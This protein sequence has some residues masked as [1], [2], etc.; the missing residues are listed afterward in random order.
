MDR[1]ACPW[2]I[3]RFIDPEAQFLFVPAD[4]VLATAS[5]VGGY[6]F[7][8]QDA[9]YG[10]RGRLCTFEVLVEDYNLTGDAALARLAHIVHA[11]DVSGEITTAPEG[12]GLWAFAEGLRLMVADDYRKVELATP[13]YD[14]LYVYCGSG[15]DSEREG[16]RSSG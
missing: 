7:D 10:H 8:A 9:R 12:A 13:F 14:A 16:M 15:L 1:V 4:Q 6:S 11:A 5:A 3:K 2:L